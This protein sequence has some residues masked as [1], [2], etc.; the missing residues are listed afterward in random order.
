MVIPFGTKM[1]P[2]NFESYPEPQTPSCSQQ[3]GCPKISQ[4]TF[5]LQTGRI[6]FP[7]V[8]ETV[9][10]YPSR[11]YSFRGIPVWEILKYPHGKD[12]YLAE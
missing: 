6:S 8:E 1:F 7:V 2:L 3:D 5:D 10:P 12:D 4:I 11:S 9:D